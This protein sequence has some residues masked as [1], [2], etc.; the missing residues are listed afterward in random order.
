MTCCDCQARDGNTVEVN[1]FEEG[2]EKISTKKSN[3]HDSTI[4]ILRWTGWFQF[5]MIWFQNGNLDNFFYISEST[6][7]PVLSL[8]LALCYMLIASAFYAEMF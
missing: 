7:I 6:V 1:T 8:L 3:G 2:K 5:S 4:R